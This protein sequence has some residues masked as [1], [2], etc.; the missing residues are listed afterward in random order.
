MLSKTQVKSVHSGEADKTQQ[1]QNKNSGERRK[2][3]TSPVQ[4]KTH[5][6]AWQWT[7]SDERTGDLEAWNMCGRLGINGT[8]VQ[9]SVGQG[10]LAQQGRKEKMDTREEKEN[11]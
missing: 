10:Q 6:C 2:C 1:Q 7:E 4:T 3:Q 8:G 9:R 11:Y 5:R